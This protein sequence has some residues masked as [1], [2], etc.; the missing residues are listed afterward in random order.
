MYNRCYF[1]FWG[2]LIGSKKGTL[3]LMK[4]EDIIANIHNQYNQPN[5]YHVVPVSS[6]QSTGLCP[7]QSVSVL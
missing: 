3:L 1:S 5:C 7:V 2:D 6:G 4:A